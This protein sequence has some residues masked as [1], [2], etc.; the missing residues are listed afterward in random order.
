MVPT[1]LAEMQQHAGA[2][3]EPGEAY[4]A[5]IRIGDPDIGRPS[6]DPVFG[7]ALGML[8]AATDQQLMEREAG[9]TLPVT[10]GI[11]GITA[12]RAVVFGLAIRLGPTE[13]LGTTDREGLTLDSATFRASLVHRARIRLFAGDELFVDGS[14]R[15]SNPDLPSIR[16]LIPP[17]G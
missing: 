3:L 15:A 14:V 12:G 6:R 2:A 4:V 8:A 5:A 9:I 17:A 1:A 16:A 10:G 11:L 13:L 7:I